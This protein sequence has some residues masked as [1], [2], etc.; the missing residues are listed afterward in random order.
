MKHL[1]SVLILLGHV[2]YAEPQLD[3]IFD[4]FG[5]GDYTHGFKVNLVR[6]KQRELGTLYFASGSSHYYMYFLMSS[7]QVTNKYKRTRRFDKIVDNFAF[8]FKFD[9]AK[10]LSN[11]GNTYQV[12]YLKQVNGNYQS[13]I[14][15]GGDDYK[16]KTSM[17]ENL[18]NGY[19]RDAGPFDSSTANYPDF[20]Y[21][22]GYEFSFKKDRFKDV[23]TAD[24]LFGSIQEIKYNNSVVS[25]AQVALT[26]IPSATP[27]PN[28]IMML[29]AGLVFVFTASSRRKSNGHAAA[30]QE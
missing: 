14:Q 20:I 10:I 13:E 22:V 27:E 24:E 19:S 11:Y 3:G 16:V 12:D 4:G 18:S 17:E 8:S 29:L 28:A 21:D 15:N 2:A 23:T 5:V 26:A 1:L 7:E 6:G 9:D 30:S 25:Q